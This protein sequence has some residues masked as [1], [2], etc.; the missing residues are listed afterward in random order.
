MDWRSRIESRVWRTVASS[1]DLRS[2]VGGTLVCKTAAVKEKQYHCA[3][4]KQGGPT[5]GDRAREGQFEGREGEEAVAGEMRDA[6][7]E[8]QG[9]QSMDSN[10]DCRCQRV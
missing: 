2:K 1:S 4:R 3:R 10:K 8:T 7:R 5:R 6:R 9:E